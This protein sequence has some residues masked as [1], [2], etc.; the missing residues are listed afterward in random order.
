MVCRARDRVTN[1]IL[2]LKVLGQIEPDRQRFRREAELLSSLTH[3]AIVRYIDHGTTSEGMHYLAMEWLEGADLSQILQ[4]GGLTLRQSLKVVRRVALALATAHEHGVI[5][6]DIKPSNIF[7]VNRDPNQVK[8]LDFG[9]A[10][11]T[12]STQAMTKTGMMV[13][14]LGYVAPEQACGDTWR[15]IRDDLRQVKLA[16]LLTPHGVVWQVTEPGPAAANR[17]KQLGIRAPPAVLKVDPTPTHTPVL[18]DPQN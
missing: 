4:A 13:G 3:P 15:N 10:R 8:V 7:L 5:H 14:T 1:E 12:V 2:A 9:I 6:R 16:Q 17:L 18:A 11:P